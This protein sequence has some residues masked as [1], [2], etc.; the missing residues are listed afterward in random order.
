MNN[1]Q[2]QPENKPFDSELP[3]SPQQA[4]LLVAFSVILIGFLGVIVR[5]ILETIFGDI[6][7]SSPFL[8]LELL[9]IVPSIYVVNRYKYS[10]KEAFRF[11]NVSILIILLSVFMGF[12]VAVIG[13]QLDRIM[14]NWF[15]MPD[16]FAEA[17]ENIF[18]T[19]NII[20]YWFILLI[21]TFGAGIC[22]EM[23]FR[24]FLQR[25]FEKKFQIAPALLIP[26]V[27][28]GLIHI[29]P[30]LFFQIVLM[31]LILGLLAW[32]TNSIYPPIIVHTL[33]NLIG[34]LYIRFH[35]PEIDAYYVSNDLVNPTIVLIAIALFIVVGKLL[36]SITEKNQ[37]FTRYVPPDH[38]QIH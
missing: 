22:E 30:W 27:L 17:M 7:W 38:K 23:L 8:L 12:V 11:N 28:F 6:S 36:W 25:I 26:A 24:G 21:A 9:I 13:D 16:V 15:P 14:Q 19:S 4:L 35:T 37:T 18:L 5:A 10:I 34:T 20:D 33:N 29:L 1:S 32:R 2:Y 3:I 31:G